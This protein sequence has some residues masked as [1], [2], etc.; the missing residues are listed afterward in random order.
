MAAPAVA[1]QAPPGMGMSTMVHHLAR[2]PDIA[3]VHGAVVCLSAR[4]HSRDDVLQAL[5]TA[6]HTSDG[7][8]RPTRG[9]LR[10]LLRRCTP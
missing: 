9:Q 5:F 10:H 4:G 3:A 8:V 1:L 7:P 2:H 6:F